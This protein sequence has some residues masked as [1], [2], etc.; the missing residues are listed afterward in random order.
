MSGNEM[1]FATLNAN[2]LGSKRFRI[3]GANHYALGCAILKTSFNFSM[4]LCV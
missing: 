2:D 4:V 3:L 1:E